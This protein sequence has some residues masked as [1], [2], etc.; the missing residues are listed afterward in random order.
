MPAEVLSYFLNHENAGLKLYFQLVLQCAP[1]LK[2]LKVSCG[3]TME[4]GEY[5]VLHSIFQGT[6]ILYRKLLEY[7]GKC[8]ILFYRSGE[9]AEYVSRVGVRSFIRKFGYEDMELEDMLEHLA[10]R[11]ASFAQGET[12]FPHEIGI[13]LGYPFEDVKGFIENEGKNCL[14]AGYWKVYSDPGTAER[15]FNSYDQAKTCA[16]NEFLTGRDIKE[17]ACYSSKIFHSY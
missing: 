14:L 6:E 17:I 15:I 12:V 10:G 5:R 9:L 4:S 16:V 1:F 11:A 3:I 7:D 8:L 2:G 13:F